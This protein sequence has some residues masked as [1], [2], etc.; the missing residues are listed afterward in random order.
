[1]NFICSG[2]CC[3][4]ETEGEWQQATQYYQVSSLTPDAVVERLDPQCPGLVPVLESLL[5]HPSTPTLTPAQVQKFSVW[6]LALGSNVTESSG[7]CSASNLL[8]LMQFCFTGIVCHLLVLSSL[9]CH[10][11]SLDKVLCSYPCLSRLIVCWKCWRRLPLIR[12]PQSSSSLIAL[13]ITRRIRWVN[14]RETSYVIITAS[15]NMIN[16]ASSML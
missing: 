11:I 15:W 9:I 8:S 3:R 2:S 13:R 4:C 12:F 10:I 7:F 1:M 5:L 16:L 14:G 6:T